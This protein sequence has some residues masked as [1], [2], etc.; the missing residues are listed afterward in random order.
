MDTLLYFAL[1]FTLLSIFIRY[2]HKQED[3]E[4]FSILL[5]IIVIVFYWKNKGLIALFLVFLIVAIKNRHEFQKELYK[6]FITCS[7]ILASLIWYAEAKYSVLTSYAVGHDILPKQFELIS[8]LGASYILMRL[9]NYVLG[10]HQNLPLLSGINYV[11]YAPALPTGPIQTTEQY[12]Q[13]RIHR[14]KFLDSSPYWGRIFWGLFKVFVLSSYLSPYAL[15]FDNVTVF[16][17]NKI[18]NV[19]LSLCAYTF[20][21]YLNFSGSIDIVI[22]FSAL[23]GWKQPENFNFPL[24]A[25]NIQDF[26]RRW[27]ITLTN[28]LKT[29]FFI[30]FV[31]K[32]N[33]NEGD[34]R[35]TLVSITGFYLVFILSALWHNFSYNFILWGVW[36]AT[37]MAAHLLYTKINCTV[38][39]FHSYIY[40]FICIFST[41]IFVSFGWLFFNYPSLSILEKVIHYD[42]FKVSEITIPPPYNTTILVNYLAVEDGTMD[43]Y[44]DSGQGLKPYAMNRAGKY[45]F[46]HIHGEADNKGNR[47]L[48]DSNYKIKID[49][50]NKT[51]TFLYSYTTS[52]KVK[53]EK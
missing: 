51:K 15:D 42:Q 11:L 29:L 25:V 23:I 34:I 47:N 40:R 20:Y 2:S 35:R 24:L 46:V 52:I 4:I 50:F 37:G 44:V 48:P 30:P 38:K 21:L 45:N 13:S 14:I 16:E 49:F 26:W 32:F 10:K 18:Q 5:S 33:F 31:K 22:A 43:V 28:T 36:H 53:N 17:F 6:K 7:V 27:H 39:F 1:P 19:I 41:F 12:S 8:V 9:L 3:A